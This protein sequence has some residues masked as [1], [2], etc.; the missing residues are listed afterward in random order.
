[1][2]V[3]KMSSK[4]Q[5]VIPAAIRR[6]AGLEAGDAVIIDF[7]AAS[8]EVRL[9][10]S[11]SIIEII[12]RIAEYGTSLIKPGTPPLLDVSTFIEENRVPRL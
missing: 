12:E 3:A 6:E 1:M 11:E 8:R 5:I 4:G 2:A 7:D 10:R 9:R